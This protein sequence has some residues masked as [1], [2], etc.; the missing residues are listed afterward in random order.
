MFSIFPNIQ[1]K[2][3]VYSQTFVI[4][5]FRPTALF[6]RCNNLDLQYDNLIGKTEE[7]RALFIHKEHFWND[8][9]STSS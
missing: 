3:K 6:C 2:I 5:F 4:I 7:E 1:I 8:D 9:L